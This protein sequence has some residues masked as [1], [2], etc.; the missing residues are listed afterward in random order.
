MKFIINYK[1]FEGKKDKFPNIKKYDVDGFTIHVG[2]DAK[3]NDYLTFNIANEN[4]IWLHTRGIP[5]S[6]VIIKGKQVNHSNQTSIPTIEILKIAAQL[7]KKHSKADKEEPCKVV[8]CHRKFVTKKPGMNDGQVELDERNLTY[9]N[10][11]TI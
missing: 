2:L 11:I 6:H 4:D 5:G 1:L 10:F 9:D 8:W 7:A 3:S